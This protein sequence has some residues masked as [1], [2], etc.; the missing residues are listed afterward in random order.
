LDSP[1]KPLKRVGQTERIIS[2]IFINVLFN[3][4]VAMRTGRFRQN[5]QS[6]QAWPEPVHFISRKSPLRHRQ[7]YK[8]DP[9]CEGRARGFAINCRTVLQ[10]GAR[11]S[12]VELQWTMTALTIVFTIIS[13]LAKGQQPAERRRQRCKL[14]RSLVVSVAQFDA[15]VRKL[16]SKL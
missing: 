15:A 12:P 14:A 6:G 10:I 7:G 2:Q 3:E 16:L 5:T 4:D 13:G 1:A 8:I 9:D 11:T